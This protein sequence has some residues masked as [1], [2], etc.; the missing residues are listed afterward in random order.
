MMARSA[1][2]KLRYNKLLNEGFILPTGTD[3]KE[4]DQV[5]LYVTL[6]NYAWHMTFKRHQRKLNLKGKGD[7]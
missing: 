2:S 1:I 4:S 3:K 7:Y 6:K 5:E